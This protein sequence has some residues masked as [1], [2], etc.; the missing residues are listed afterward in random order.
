VPAERR[1]DVGGQGVEDRGLAPLEDR[2]DHGRAD[3]RAAGDLDLMLDIALGE[4]EHQV[5]ILQNRA[6]GDHRLGD[7]DAV[8]GQ[9]HDQAG[10]RP[11]GGGDLAGEHAAESRLGV[12]D[13]AGQQGLEGF[14][15]A[16][17]RARAEIHDRQQQALAITRLVMAGHVDQLVGLGG[18]AQ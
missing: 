14:G 7:L 4:D 1:L 9:A 11:T 16:A 17:A 15:C 13:E 3:G 8:Q 2:R 5:M 12:D 6:G 10:R 18:Q